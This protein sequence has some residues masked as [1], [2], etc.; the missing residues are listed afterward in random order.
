MTVALAPDDEAERWGDK[1]SQLDDAVVRGKTV[2]FP[3]R[4][5]ANVEGLRT[6][7][8]Y[9]LVRIGGHWYVVGRDHGRDGTRMFRLS[10]VTGPLRYAS[11][12][13]RDFTTPPDFDPSEY[14][15]RPPWLIGDETGTAR[16]LV[17][18][19]LAWWV[20]RS[21]PCV[22]AEHVDASGYAL[23]QTPYADGSALVAWVIGLGRRAEIVAPDDL[24]AVA[25]AALKAVRDAHA[26]P[27]GPLPRVPPPGKRLPD[28]PQDDGSDSYPPRAPPPHARTP[29]ILDGP[30]PWRAGASSRH[31]PRSGSLPRGDTG[32]PLAPHPGEPWRGHLPAQRADRWRRCGGGQRTRRGS[33]GRPGPALAAHG[34]SPTPGPGCGRLRAALGDAGRPGLGARQGGGFAREESLCRARWRWKT[35]CLRTRTSSA[36]S[37]ERCATGSWCVSSTT[38]LRKRR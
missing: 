19:D 6:L 9:A 37:T 11:K 1:L 3:Y 15:A 36:R 22:S 18:D 16:L 33:D 17:A 26:A 29:L 8:P 10:R 13:P 35:S 4:T 2:V 12:K 5:A 31:T 27:A 14:R 23:L 25:Y 30:G 20:T 7:D 38:R 32:R 34:P 21:Y 28:T 24:R